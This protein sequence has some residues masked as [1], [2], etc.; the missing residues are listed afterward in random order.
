MSWLRLAVDMPMQHPCITGI[1]LLATL[2]HF[3]FEEERAAMVAKIAVKE[4]Q[5]LEMS[6]FAVL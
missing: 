1:H 5:V 3:L 2:A 4:L 6:G